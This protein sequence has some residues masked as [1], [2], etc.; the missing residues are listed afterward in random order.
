MTRL[1]AIMSVTILVGLTSIRVDAATIVGSWRIIEAN[2]GYCPNSRAGCA[3]AWYPQ[4]AYKNAAGVPAAGAYVEVRNTAGRLGWGYADA[5]GDIAINIPT[6]NPVNQPIFFRFFFQTSKFWIGGPLVW[7]SDMPYSVLVNTSSA[8]PIDLG[9][10]FA[11]TVAAPSDLGNIFSAAS[12]QFRLAFDYVPHL[13]SDAGAAPIQI[14][15]PDNGSPS[16]A[17]QPTTDDRISIPDDATDVSGQ[18]PFG[19]PTRTAHEMGHWA[20]DHASV[21]DAK[22]FCGFYNFPSLPTGGGWWPDTQEW[23]CAAYSEG[24]AAFIS[25]VSR[26]WFDQAAT[27]DT[28]VPSDLLSCP[29][30]LEPSVATSCT[31]NNPCGGVAERRTARTVMRFLWDA[32]DN[33]SDG[34]CAEA[35]AQSYAALVLGAGNFATGSGNGQLS[36]WSNTTEVDDDGNSSTP[37]SDDDGFNDTTAPSDK[38]ETRALTTSVSNNRRDQNGMFDYRVRYAAS[39]SPSVSLLNSY[40]NNCAFMGN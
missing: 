6:Q 40:R 31:S 39:T 15:Y 1:I 21:S 13:V 8:T 37:A 12:R 22:G 3:S 2:Q 30:L 19:G 28:C 16:A 4:A 36:E 5:N 20:D 23:G 7:T 32:Y 25:D 33:S 18:G 9:D 35:D 10:W 14:R 11:G 17:Y 27:A 24:F 26:Y 38:D 34:I 29:T